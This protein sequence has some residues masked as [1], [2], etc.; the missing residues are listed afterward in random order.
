MFKALFIL[1]Y[2]NR[3]MRFYFQNNEFSLFPILI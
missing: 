3:F 2:G 1:F